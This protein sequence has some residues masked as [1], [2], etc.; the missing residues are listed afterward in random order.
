MNPMRFNINFSS[1]TSLRINNNDKLMNGYQILYIRDAF[2]P[3]FLM[4]DNS[5][6]RIG[7]LKRFKAFFFSD[8]C[9]SV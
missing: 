1:L 2:L 7:Y 8:A 4:S 5:I 9:S 6:T 3:I